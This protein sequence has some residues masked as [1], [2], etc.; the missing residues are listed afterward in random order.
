MEN[1]RINAPNTCGR[2]EENS[3]TS[4]LL[5]RNPQEVAAFPQAHCM[6]SADSI[7]LKNRGLT[8]KSADPQPLLLLLLWNRSS[9]SSVQGET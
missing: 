3:V 6:K 7:P 9:L 2:I 8:T 4:Y 5:L 1:L